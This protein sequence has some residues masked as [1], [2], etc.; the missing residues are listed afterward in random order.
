MKKIGI[1]YSVINKCVN[2]SYENE[3]EKNDNSILKSDKNSLKK[4]NTK[5]F[6]NIFIDDIIY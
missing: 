4:L 1:D 5:Y 6:P 2:N 3:D